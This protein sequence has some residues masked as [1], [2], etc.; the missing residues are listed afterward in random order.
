[1]VLLS[2][3]AYPKYRFLRTNVSYTPPGAGAPENYVMTM[4]VGYSGEA[5]GMMLLW[6]YDSAKQIAQGF[7]QWHGTMT[8]NAINLTWDTS[9]GDAAPATT[10]VSTLTLD[11]T[12]NALTGTFVGK[13]G[14]TFITFTTGI[15]E[16]KGCR[17]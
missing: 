17:M 8:G 7:L 14:G 5:S 9:Q 4:D 11:P 3:V 16:W 2:H 6:P 12:T 1:M 10:K 13:D 15:D